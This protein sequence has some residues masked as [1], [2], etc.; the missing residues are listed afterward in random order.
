[1]NA[2]TREDIARWFREGKAQGATHMIIVCDTFDWEDYP[3]YVMPGENIQEKYGEWKKKGRIMEV[4][5][6]HKDME[7]QLNEHRAFHFD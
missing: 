3:V 2:A 5:S 4:Y 7:T 6:L 1:M